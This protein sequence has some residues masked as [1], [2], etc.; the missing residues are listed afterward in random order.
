MVRAV[1][2]RATAVLRPTSW[3]LRRLDPLTLNLWTILGAGLVIVLVPTVYTVFAPEIG[4]RALAVRIV[5]VI[6][7]LCA[8][9]LA[10]LSG[11]RQSSLV[12][13]L[14]GPRSR[15]RTEMQEEATE[16]ILGALLTP[17]GA[18]G[19]YQWRLFL[20][21]PDDPRRLIVPPHAPVTSNTTWP[22]GVG[23]TGVA[24][25]TGISQYAVD[26]E[27]AT[28]YPVPPDELD[29]VRRA[30]HEHLR[31][32]AAMPI[33]SALGTTLGVLTA[34]SEKRSLYITTV[35]GEREHARLADAVA[36]VLIDIMGLPE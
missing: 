6:I 17:P 15:E 36:R 18:L 11:L 7:W 14:V 27:I 33:K 5:V 34:S 29:D 10:V 1:T 2:A 8:A 21:D 23:V 12:E 13:Q 32:V 35:D 9:L 3:L 16:L 22:V 4:S 30:R 31:V 25:A 26:H 24:Y 20:P 19:R 28:L